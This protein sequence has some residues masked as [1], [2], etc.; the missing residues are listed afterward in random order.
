M[1]STEP[2]SVDEQVGDPTPPRW[3]WIVGLT[4]AI[5]GFAVAAYLTYEHFT[6]SS[7]LSCP[8]TGGI[9]NCFKV[10]TSK[11]SKIMGIPVSVLGLI[12]FAVTIAAQT[13][14]AWAS[15]SPWIRFGRIAWQALGVL[16][17]LW[18]VY[19]ELFKLHAI[20]LWCTA[21]HVLSLLVFITTIFGTLATAEPAP[22]DDE[23][24]EAD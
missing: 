1:S 18:L 12:F 17:A 14:Q 15:R 10:T 7:T 24:D 13:P 4:L 16:T 11:Y 3:P 6:S 21:V 5:L 22:F 2:P 9:I 23:W 20:C 19:A 8:A